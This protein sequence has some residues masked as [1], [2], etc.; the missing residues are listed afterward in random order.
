MNVLFVDQYGDLGGA[1]LCLLDLVPAV[2]EE[3]WRAQAAVPEGPLAKRLRAFG[4]GVREI[5]V[6]EY[7]AGRKSLADMIRYMGAMRRVASGLREHEADLVYVNGPRVLPAVALARPRGAVLFHAHSVVRDPASRLVLDWSLR[8]TR[9][10]VVA[11]S[12]FIDQGVVVP[13]G[14]A[15][16][17]RARVPRPAPAIGMIGRIAPEKGQLEF[18]EAAGRLSTSDA[19]FIIC[20]APLLASPP[21]AGRVRER[22]RGLPVEFLDWTDDVA[23]VL[24]GLDILTVP[25]VGEEGSGRVVLEAFSAGVP[26]VAFA[27]GG[28]PELIS[29]GRT[30]FLVKERTGAALADRL[31]EVLAAPALVAEVARNVRTEWETRYTLEHFR[32]RMIGVMRDAAAGR[33]GARDAAE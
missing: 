4:V 29:E 17:S 18:V 6:G 19:R 16:M 30:G 24:S 14:V 33:R 7:G 5:R 21:Y 26:V 20:G 8:R 27:S 23:S 3:G 31:R 2:L 11:A 10:K 32:R 13:N 22:A 12:K 25:S 15:D 9:A 28:I 1:Q